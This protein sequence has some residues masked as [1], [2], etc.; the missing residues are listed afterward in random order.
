MVDAGLLTLRVADT[1]PL[2]GVAR[3]HERLAAGG[4]RGRLVLVP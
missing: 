2:A 3:A 1:I 4:L